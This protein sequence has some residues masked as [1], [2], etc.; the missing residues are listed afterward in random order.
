MKKSILF[1]LL[2]SAMGYTKTLN[3]IAMSVNGIGI[4][5]AEIKAVQKQYKVPKDKAIDMLVMD[6]I[7]QSALKDITV[8]DSE[9]NERISM[10]AKQNG[11]S[12]DKMK[13]VLISQGTKWQKYKD[14]IKMAIKKDKFFRQE[15]APNIKR[16]ND[17]I[18]K[19]YYQKNKQLLFM[20]T[21]ISVIEYSA[22][23]E[24]TMNNFLKTKNK[25]GIKSKKKRLYT[26][27]LDKSMLNILLRT[28]NGAY[29]HSMNAGDRYIVYK[30][31]SQNGKRTMSFEEAKPLLFGM[32]QRDQKDKRLK[33]YFAQQKLNAKIKKLR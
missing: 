25:Q 2:F 13:K 32:Y 15:I 12:V 21:S 17:A 27:Q 8:D 4:T 16:P 28:Q 19:E 14:R 6:R 20:P 7:Q 31:L 18:L 29:T 3:A 30:V 11:I 33:E 10:I 23:N 24:K 1:L 5:T 22:K 9:I 26:K